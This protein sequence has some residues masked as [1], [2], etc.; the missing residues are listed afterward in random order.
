MQ[1]GLLKVTVGA[2]V[3]GRFAVS[4]AVV[5]DNVI[6][7]LRESFDHACRA[8]AIVGNTVKVD[9]SR[10]TGVGGMTTPSLQGNVDAGKVTSSQLS[11][12]FD[13]T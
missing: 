5:S 6:A 3:A 10:L 13:S 2:N 1:V 11:G 12:V 4:A 9:Q 8:D 7:A